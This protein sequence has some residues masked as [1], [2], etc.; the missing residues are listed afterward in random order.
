MM[1]LAGSNLLVNVY[2]PASVYRESVL[3]DLALAVWQDAA[4]SFIEGLAL[5]VNS[6]SPAPPSP[7]LRARQKRQLMIPR[8]SDF[9]SRLRILVAARHLAKRSRS[10]TFRLSNNGK[11][12]VAEEGAE[13]V[14][15]PGVEPPLTTNQ[16][17]VMATA[18]LMARWQPV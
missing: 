1:S 6:F 17:S 7:C 9:D 4:V 8:N 2:L 18:R 16:T 3:H 5:S 14:E 15:L 12:A 11:R 10:L 13:A